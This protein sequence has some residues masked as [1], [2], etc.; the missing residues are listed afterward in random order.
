MWAEPLRSLGDRLRG[1]NK[2]PQPQLSHD[3]HAVLSVAPEIR[4]IRWSHMTDR[5]ESDG[6]PEP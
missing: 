1:R 5:T 3:L 2:E 6:S 4:D